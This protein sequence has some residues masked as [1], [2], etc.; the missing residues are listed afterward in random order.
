VT[1]SLPLT[2][3]N[4]LAVPTAGFSVHDLIMSF[5]QEKNKKDELYQF[6]S[7]L[8]LIFFFSIWAKD[9]IKSHKI[10][11]SFFFPF[12][13]SFYFLFYKDFIML[14]RYFKILKKRV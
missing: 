4:P 12:M 1:L 9:Y 7:L 2:V 11:F 3:I 6:P 5:A 8:F 13:A 10:Y 14:N